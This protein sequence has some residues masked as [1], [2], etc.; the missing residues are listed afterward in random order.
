MSH[1]YS[2]DEHIKSREESQDYDSNSQDNDYRQQQS[3]D[4]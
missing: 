2:D 3:H 4:E 1:L